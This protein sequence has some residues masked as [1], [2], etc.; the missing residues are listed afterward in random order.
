MRTLRQIIA[1]AKHT[2]AHADDH[3]EGGTLSLLTDLFGHLRMPTDEG[4]TL[5]LLEQVERLKLRRINLNIIVIGSDGFTTEDYERI[6]NALPYLRQMMATGQ[7]GVGR[8]NR[9]AVTVA[10]A[11]GYDFIGDD[12]E[13]SDLP[14]QWTVHNDGLDIFIVRS[15][16][17]I[18]D[19]VEAAGQSAVDGPCNKDNTLEMSGCVV[20]RGG[21][22]LPSTSGRFLG[23]A[24]AHEIGHYLGLD[25]IIDIDDIDEATPAQQDN[26]MY[27]G[28]LF[29]PARFN[30]TQ[31]WEMH[32]HC[33][34]WSGC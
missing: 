13:A 26:I 34:V 6:E 21:G 19:D 5:S 25:H 3:R 32:E 17:W 31:A 11:G 33:L 23:T 24:I 22:A 16:T 28:I 8:V 14:D 12:C 30:Q 10:D 18:F 29:D 27:P 9:Y 15:N 20:G 1:C 7:I 4:L 2:G